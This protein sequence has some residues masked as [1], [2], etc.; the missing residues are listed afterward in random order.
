MQYHCLSLLEAG[1][2]VSFIGYDGEDL[3]EALQNYDSNRLHVIRFH[4]H[5]PPISFKPLYFAWRL[6]SLT[7]YLIHAMFFSIRRQKHPHHQPTS[8]PQ[9]KSV[10]VDFV[11]VQN[12]PALPLLVVAWLFCQIQKWEQGRRPGLI[13]DWH[14]LGYSM[15]RDGSMFQKIAWIYERIMAPLADGHL[16]VTKAMKGHLIKN[17]NL[18]ETSNIEVL[19][20]CP[21]DLF[22]PLDVEQQHK[23][24]A[25]LE[26]HFCDA[27]PPSWYATK[28]SSK[29]TLF[30]E[31]IGPNRYS[32]R[33]GRPALITSSTSWTP[34]EDFGVLLRA[35]EHLD[36]RIRQGEYDSDNF[37]VFVVVTGKG[38]ERERYEERISKLQLSHIAIATVWLEPGDYPKLIAC[39]DL[40]ISLHTSTSGLDL[41]MKILDLFGCQ[42]PVVAHDFSCLHELVQD[43]S[44]GRVFQEAVELSQ[45][46]YDLLSPLAALENTPTA[47]HSF[48]DLQKYSETLHEGMRWNTNWTEHAL[49]VILRATPNS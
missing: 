4:V 9:L 43:R 24:L 28:D 44:N 18:G 12:P 45:L 5:T 31:E 35:L 36:E 19:Y 33:R 37:K 32:F 21:P 40:G 26:K 1:H 20:D 22:Q 23:I 48:G 11:L 34:D 8:S 7:L 25:K 30:T 13:I 3:I 10:A 17:M 42:V 16:T 27:C 29:Q 14:N 47:N 2:R 46:L 49:P 6:L 15:L 39:A 38:P 41:P